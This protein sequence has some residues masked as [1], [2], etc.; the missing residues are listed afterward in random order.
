MSTYFPFLRGKLNELLALR[1]LDARIAQSNTVCPII[2]PV[3]ANS[4]SRISLDHYIEAGMPFLFITNPKHGQFEGRQRELC[5]EFIVEGPLAEYDNYIPALYVDRYTELPETEYFTRTCQTTFRA[6][7]YDGEPRSDEVREW[8]NTDTQIYHHVI[9][10]GKVSAQFADSLP[11]ARQVVIRDNF[12]RRAK[13]AD[14]PPTEFYTDLNTSAGN[15]ENLNWGDYS[16]QGDYFFE[17]GGPAYAVAIHHIHYEGD[18]LNV[19]HFISDRQQTTADVPGK[20]MEALEKLVAA[21]P[22]LTPNDTSACDEYRQLAASRNSRGLGYL[23]RLA[24]KH[25]LELMLQ[26]E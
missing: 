23:K 1:E 21:L 12:N 11:K 7:I 16:I 24:I 17:T 5:D 22:S 10:D 8:C 6:V 15:P 9:L 13:N 4:S 20:I 2:E 26:N 19:S 3:K 18:V 25:H 14:Y